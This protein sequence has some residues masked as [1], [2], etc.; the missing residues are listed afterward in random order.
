MP[1]PSSWQP[2]RTASRLATAGVKGVYKSATESSGSM[3]DG[4]QWDSSPLPTLTIRETM[5]FHL[6]N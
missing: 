1:K 2:R 3:L 4:S 6:R 5:K